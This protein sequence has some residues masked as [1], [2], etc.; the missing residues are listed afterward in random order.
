MKRIPFIASTLLASGL[1]AASASGAEIAQMGGGR[2]IHGRICANS[3]PVLTQPASNV[4][5]CQLSQG[6]LVWVYKIVRDNA[7]VRVQSG[8]CYGETGW[9]PEEILGPPEGCG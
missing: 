4:F 2:I 5:R 7:Q 1:L 8:P 6:E 3:V 9:V